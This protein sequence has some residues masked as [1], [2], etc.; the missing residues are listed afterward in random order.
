W[1]EL[2]G[3]DMVQAACAWVQ[4]LQSILDYLRMAWCMLVRGVAVVVVATVFSTV[5]LQ[6]FTQREEISIAR[7]V[8]ATESLVR[9]PFLY[10]GA[11][12]GLLS[13]ALPV[14]IAWG[15]LQPLG[16]AINRLAS[17]Y[18]TELA[19]RL[20]DGFSLLLAGVVVAILGSL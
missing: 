9:R 17:S 1:R 7:L 20:P 19:L 11:L 18:G 15:A 10:L 12:T 5:R 2:K 3:V 14:A 6:A 4:R 8:G 13:S 16:T